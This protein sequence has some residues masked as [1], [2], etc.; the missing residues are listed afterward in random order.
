MS[1]ADRI[2][3][4]Q[5]T[6]FY[7]DFLNNFDQNPVT[8][9]LARVTNVEAVKQSIRNLILT[10]KNERPYQP[11]I[12]SKIRSLLFEPMDSVTEETLRVTIQ[13]TVE[14]EPRANLLSVRI[15][16]EPSLNGYLVS[17]I[18]SMINIPEQIELQ[19]ILRRVR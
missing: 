3:P 17:I 19:I 1:R 5:K 16:A 8:G 9:Y 11:Y 4:I 10:N 7:S 2:S 14:Q 15:K 18:F 6:I 12:G 13:E